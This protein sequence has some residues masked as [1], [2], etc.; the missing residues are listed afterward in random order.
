MARVAAKAAEAT[1]ILEA[2]KD[3]ISTNEVFELGLGLGRGRE[4]KCNW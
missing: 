4:K 2:V 3:L 1:G